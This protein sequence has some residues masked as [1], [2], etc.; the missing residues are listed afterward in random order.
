MPPP[1]KWQPSGGRR[2]IDIR[3]SARWLVTYFEGPVLERANR[4]AVA[5]GRK[6]SDFIP[7]SRKEK[8]LH[9]AYELV[10]DH[11]LH[12]VVAVIDWLFSTWYGQLPYCVLAERT[13]YVKPSDLK[14]TRIAQI[15]ENYDNLI[16]EMRRGSC[17]DPGAEMPP[18]Q[19]TK[20]QYDEPFSD[21]LAEAKVTELVQ[22]FTEFQ[23][24]CGPHKEIH[25]TRTWRWAKSF[26]IMLSYRGYEFDDLKMVVSALRDYPDMDRTRY[27]D[28]YDLDRDGEWEHIL[29]A[30]KLAQLRAERLAERRAER[31]AERRASDEPQHS[32]YQRQDA[33]DDGW[34]TSR[35]TGS[36]IR[37]LDMSARTPKPLDYYTRN[38]TDGS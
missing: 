30:A 27:N 32:R 33:L 22:L 13:D 21:P 7:D 8:W 12:E 10:V 14:L 38:R 24:A 18:A 17:P 26:R 36:E 16:A 25:H 6:L 1:V 23:L 37:F 2:F 9:N 5:K 15:Q 31:G 11:P 3:D 29:A 20:I 4:D 19:R 34:G 35:E 28:A